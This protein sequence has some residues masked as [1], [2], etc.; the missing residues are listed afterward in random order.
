[1][2]EAASCLQMVFKIG[3]SKVFAIF[4]GRHLR[5]GQKEALAQVFSYEFSSGQ[6]YYESSAV[7]NTLRVFCIL[8][9]CH[10]YGKFKFLVK[11]H[12]IYCKPAT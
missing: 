1:M 3:V 11:Q 8:R 12:G 6:L 5:W 2:T 4:T 10:G 7:N 9:L